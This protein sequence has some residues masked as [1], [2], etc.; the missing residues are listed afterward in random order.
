VLDAFR[1][2]LRDLGYAEGQNVV[3][4]NRNSRGDDSLLPGL[5]AD[6]SS[7]LQDGLHEPPPD[8][9]GLHQKHRRRQ[10]ERHGRNKEAQRPSANCR[11][12][13]TSA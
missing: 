12:P 10:A 7:A 9:S 2:E 13:A 3:F 1:Q 5:A 11:R 6:L 8:P 4:E